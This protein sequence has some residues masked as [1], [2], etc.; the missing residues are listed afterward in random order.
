MRSAAIALQNAQEAVTSA[1]NTLE[2][3]I[4]RA[5]FAGTIASVGVQTYDQASSGTSVAT[6]VTN[7]ETASIT[8][9]EVD[10][11][12]LKVGQK[13][14]LTFDALP[15]VS[16]A[17]TVSVIN[18]I[19]TVSQGVVSYG[20]IVTFD[21]QN[22]SVL[23]G[24]SATANIVIGIETG[25]L[26]PSSAVKVSNGQS[27]V[28]VFSPTL[29]G[30]NS[31]TGATSPVAPTR[32]NVTTGLTDNSNVIVQTGISAGAQVVTKTITGTS[33]TTASS[34]TQ[35]TSIFG[36]GGGGIRTGGAGG[37]AVRA[38]GQ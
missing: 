13:A 14:T 25:L 36:I 15:G 7:E 10:A 16:I 31:S 32:T 33:A 24:M 26:V 28:Q 9:N 21:T 23:P 5:P 4:V 11:S 2:N 34:A 27:Y 1:Q 12:K 35:S 3:Y 22:A 38:P 30:S 6:L 19:G 29:A 8:V 17:G 20:A 18:T 37:G